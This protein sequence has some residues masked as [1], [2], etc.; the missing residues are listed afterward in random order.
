MVAGGME[1]SPGGEA[2]T[3]REWAG[4]RDPVFIQGW[5]QRKVNQSHMRHETR[6]R[7][8]LA[9][10]LSLGHTAGVALIGNEG[11]GGM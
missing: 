11:V 1:S 7:E 9:S 6:P 2:G 4:G 3:G 8:S 10:R 5:W